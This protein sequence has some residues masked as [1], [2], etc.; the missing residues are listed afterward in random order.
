M[1]ILIADDLQSKIAKL[2]DVLTQNC[3]LSRDQIEVAQTSV[4]ARRLLKDQFFDLFIMDILLPAK[5]EDPPARAT[6]LDLLREIMEEG[7]CV[8]PAHILG[9]TAY[10]DEAA[11]AEPYFREQLWNLIKF[12]ETDD[13]WAKPI[14]NC[15]EYIKDRKTQTEDPRHEVDVC[16]LTAL[17]DPEMD[18]VLRL[19]WRWEAAEPLDN[20]QFVRRGFITVEGQS[21]SVVAAVASRMGMIAT[22]LLAS[23][24]IARYRPRILGMTGICAGIKDKTALGD[25]IFADTSWDWQSGK[26]IKDK[27]NSQFSIDPHH[28]PVDEFLRARAQQLRSERVM[29]NDLRLAWPT[30]PGQELRLLVGPIASGSAVL[31]DGQIANEIRTQQRTLLGVE[32]EAYG[33]FAAASTAGQPKPMVLVMKSV[34]D[35]ADPDKHDAMQ[36][37]ASYTSA[38]AFRIFVERNI[39]EIVK[40][41]NR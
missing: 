41:T 2:V 9:L 30:P 20:S 8:K 25:I 28:L 7:S 29:W 15:V 23:K 22:A 14:C 3:G 27:E 35:F 16:I 4:E 39:V 13:D 5:P 32:M 34:C 19:P 24:M 17:Q 12:D 18:A 10:P 6:S 38:Q 26:R 1:K 36:A 37:Y 31:A 33:L 11:A 40:A 21:Y